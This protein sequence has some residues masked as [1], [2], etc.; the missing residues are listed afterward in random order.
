MKLD[1]N[2]KYS[3]EGKDGEWQFSNTIGNKF[4]FRGQKSVV[5]LT[6]QQVSERVKDK[7]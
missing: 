1:P 4:V 2:E 7:K 5:S 3:I 6:Q